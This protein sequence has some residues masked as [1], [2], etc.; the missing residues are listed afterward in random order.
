MTVWYF[1]D[2]LRRYF[3]ARKFPT[4]EARDEL[5]QLANKMSGSE[6]YTN[7]RRY[8]PLQITH[9]LVTNAFRYFLL[10]N[11]VH[12]AIRLLISFLIQSFIVLVG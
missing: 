4:G 5:R 12:S 3:F 10:Q 6:Y 7:L 11:S 1:S 2:F 9:Q 8:I